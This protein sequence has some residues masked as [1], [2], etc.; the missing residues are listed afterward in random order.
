MEDMIKTPEVLKTGELLPIV[1]LMKCTHI[2]KWEE[3]ENI[4]LELVD[5]HA[6]AAIAQ[7]TGND[8]RFE[9]KITNKA[10]FGRFNIGDVIEV[11]L[12]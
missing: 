6:N 3:Q 1:L 5:S 12:R 4:H 2:A 11:T 7:Y 9:L 8:T 10:R